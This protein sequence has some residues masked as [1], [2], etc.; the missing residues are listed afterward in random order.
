MSSLAT[1]P[2]STGRAPSQ[3]TGSIRLGRIRV[4]TDS[5]V[6][7]CLA[8]GLIVVTF[9]ASGGVELAPNTWIEIAL[10]LV[11]TAAAVVV[12]LI[13]APGRRWG[14]VTMGLFAVLVALTAASVSWSVAPDT[15]W[16]ES[17]RTLSYMA[18]FGSSIAAARLFPGRWPAVLAAVCLLATVVSGYALM[19]KVLPAS[20]DPGETFGRLRAPFDYWNATGLIAAMGLPPCLW[21]GARRERGRAIR[22]FAVPAATILIS[23]IVL[24]YSRGAVLVA[25]IG[26]A[27]WFAFVPLR[28]RAAL[29][30]ALGAA[31]A[32][33]VSI[34]AVSTH[35]LTANLVPLSQ[36][37]TAGHAL[38]VLLVLTLAVLTVAGFAS[39]FAMDRITLPARARRR[40]GTALLVAVALLPV[41]GV[42]GLAVS[43]R[44]LTGQISH[45]WDTLTSTTS[46]VGNGPARLVQLG[47]SRGRYWSEGVRVGEH[48]LLRG[49]GAL[50][51][52][53][54]VT[55]YT[56][57]PRS[58]GHAHSYAV[59]TFADFGLIGV[60]LMVAM[61][62]SWSLAARRTLTPGGSGLPEE[63]RAE[64]SG[65]LTMFAIVVIFGLHSAIDWTWFVPGTAIPALVCAGWVAGR[66]PI[67]DAVGTRG[68]KRITAAP[69]TAAAAIGLLA[70]ALLGC[71]A[72]WQP[73]RAANADAAALNA[74]ASGNL[75]SAIADASRAAADY[76]VGVDPLFELA[77]FYRATGD[78]QAAHAQLVRAIERQPQNGQTWLA[79][80]DFDL[81]THHP[82]RALGPATKAVTLDRSS[83]RA[84]ADVAQARAQIASAA[85]GASG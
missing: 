44:G 5:A 66:G 83:S 34:Y 46:G 70:L 7:L 67:G 14:A 27:G 61:L 81:S 84:A 38:G 74:V 69:G 60:A 24:S 13:G 54:A 85:T 58:V 47:N 28:L 8:L 49:V 16:V 42:A 77:A 51:Y 68:R 39:A 25:V 45:V 6:A 48:S 64:R 9:V 32:A 72:V 71:W 4:S 53:T 30:L 10:A 15:S 78:Q 75:R 79:L 11:G 19:V 59:E 29:V 65:L 62:A 20:L 36:R 41:A 82:G 73:L 12:L 1:A 22:A 18:V 52:G 23:V 40:I 57:D 33:V 2:A 63:Q 80:A 43:S 26:L 3:T 21:A 31:G 76:P 56:Y 17:G 35:A 55:R 50:G 37:T